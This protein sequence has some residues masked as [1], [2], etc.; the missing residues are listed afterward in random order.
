M[1]SMRTDIQSVEKIRKTADE[2]ARL[3]RSKDQGRDHGR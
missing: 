1:K 2:F 3:E